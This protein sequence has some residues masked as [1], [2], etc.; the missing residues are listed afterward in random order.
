MAKERRL[1]LVTSSAP[2]PYPPSDSARLLSSAPGYGNPPGCHTGA[3]QDHYDYDN[4]LWAAAEL[5]RATGEQRF[6]T[7]VEKWYNGEGPRKLSSN[8]GAGTSRLAHAM[9][10][11]TA[12]SYTHLTLP[13][14]A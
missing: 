6:A 2:K 11:Y 9:E 5:Y 12:V 3:Y 7:F 10:A 1:N 8:S 14:K 4:R 13:T